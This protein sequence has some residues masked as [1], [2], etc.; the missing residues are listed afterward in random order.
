MTLSD[1]DLDFKVAVFFD[2][3]YLKSGA[4]DR[5]TVTTEQQ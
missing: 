1:P 3:K 4:R 2:I 5:V